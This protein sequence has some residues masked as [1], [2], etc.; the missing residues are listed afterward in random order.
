MNNVFLDHLSS[1]DYLGTKEL[2][3]GPMYLG[4]LQIITE[5]VGPP[6]K[7]LDTS[8]LKQY[9]LNS[10]PRLFQSLSY[11]PPESNF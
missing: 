3:E 4:T 8:P 10:F 7:T 9:V 6:E 2:C 11:R 5:N 1:S